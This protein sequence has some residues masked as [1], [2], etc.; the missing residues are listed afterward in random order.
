MAEKSNQVNEI[1][2]LPL[3]DAFE[4]DVSELLERDRDIVL[5]TIDMDSF[6]SVNEEYGHDVGD[7]V[8]IEAGQYFRSSISANAKL[9]RCG[10]DQFAVVYSDGEQKEDV[11]LEMETMRRGYAVKT[12][13]GITTISIGISASPEDGA[14]YL[15]LMR[16]AEGALYRAKKA[17][18]NRVCLA[19]E[20]KMVTKTSHYSEQQLRRLTKVSKREGI[21]EAI[22]LRE[23]LDMVLKKYD[24]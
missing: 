2:R 16:M 1:L 12:P 10:G 3:G 15:E 8:L 17:G 9:Y 22:L 13:G 7:R 14:E 11:F 19:R 18:H 24:A 23:A 5:A 21:G 20:E 4:R 6:M